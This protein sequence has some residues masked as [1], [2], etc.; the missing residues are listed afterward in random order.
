GDNHSTGLG[1]EGLLR[2]QWANYKFDIDWVQTRVENYDSRLYFWDLNLP[3]EMRSRVYTATGYYPGFKLAIGTKQNYY[4][5]GRIRWLIP[6]SPN[7][8]KLDYEGGLL[9]EVNL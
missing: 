3:N 4:I 6:F 7:K 8:V 1:L 9:I 5:A 2:W